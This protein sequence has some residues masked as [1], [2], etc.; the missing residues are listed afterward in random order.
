MLVP[1]L[2]HV[3]PSVM[4]GPPP[5]RTMLLTLLGVLL[6]GNPR[7]VDLLHFGQ[8]MTAT[9]SSPAIDEKSLVLVEVAP[10]SWEQGQVSTPENTLHDPVS[11]VLL[12]NRCLQMLHSLLF[13]ARNTINQAFC[14]EVVRV[15]GLDWVLLWTQPNLHPSTVVWGLRILVALCSNPLL[16]QK[17]REGSASG[18]WLQDTQRL[19]DKMGGLLGYQLGTS[20]GAQKSQEI[21]LDA[22]HVPGFQRLSWQLPYHLEV[23]EVYF[24]I[25]ALMMGQPVK[26]L[27]ADSKVSGISINSLE[28]T[29][30][31]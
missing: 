29:F 12:R 25:M 16:L 3:L 26:L 2:L 19:Q 8:L 4:T 28:C 17:F 14:N 30:R 18:G 23:P 13:N 1:R 6:A 21:R 24:L 27:P 10:V 7:P 11:C 5:T 9:L 20:P 31:T 22:V 15:L